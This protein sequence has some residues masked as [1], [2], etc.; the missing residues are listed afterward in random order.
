MRAILR[1]QAEVVNQGECETEPDL[2]AVLSVRPVFETGPAVSS[3]EENSETTSPQ[4]ESM[5]RL[6][7]SAVAHPAQTRRAKANM[8]RMIGPR[9][10]EGATW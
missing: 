5:S 4:M 9:V 6:S 8:R 3:C 2:A 10:P 1:A 7:L